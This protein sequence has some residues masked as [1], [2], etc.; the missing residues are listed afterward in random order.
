MS[1]RDTGRDGANL[2]FFWILIAAL[3]IGSI[4]AFNHLFY[5][6]QRDRGYISQISGLITTYC[7]AGTSDTKEASRQD[8]AGQRDGFPQ[9]W[10]ALPDS[11]RVKAEAVINQ[12][13]GACK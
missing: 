3:V 7:S 11:L 1:I 6:P 2:V 10:N 13:E 8:I 5:E 12:E 9:R 4:F